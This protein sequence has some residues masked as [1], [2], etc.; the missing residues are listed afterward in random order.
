MYKLLLNTLNAYLCHRFQ[1]VFILP[2]LIALIIFILA[3][4]S[5]GL[6][7]KIYLI[8]AIH[9][10]LAVIS[11]SLPTVFLTHGFLV[12]FLVIW[13]IPRPSNKHALIRG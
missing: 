11:S 3:G 6:K 9:F 1:G 2:I 10:R 5:M 12:N 7:T 4:V 8:S 13:L